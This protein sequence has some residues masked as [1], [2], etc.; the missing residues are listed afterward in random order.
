MQNIRVVIIAT[1]EQVPMPSIEAA[2][3]Y[4]FRHLD[5]PTLIIWD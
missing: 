4:R 1:G 3:A 2:R 5:V